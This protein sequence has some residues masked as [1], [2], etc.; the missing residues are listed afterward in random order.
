V[1]DLI[2]RS[3]D[4]GDA[5]RSKPYPDIF[6]AAIEKL[7]VAPGDTLIVGDTPYDGEAAVAAGAEFIGVLSGGFP[8]EDLRASGATAIYRDPAHLLEQYESTPLAA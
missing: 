6:K 4:S 2:D 8:E 7:K 3:T 1:D 5:E